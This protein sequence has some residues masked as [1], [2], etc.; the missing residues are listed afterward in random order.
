MVRVLASIHSVDIDRA[1]LND[2]GKH[3]EFS[4][5]ISFLF[6][7]KTAKSRTIQKDDYLLL[8]TCQF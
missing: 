3:G 2:F 7:L 6:P 1:G 5:S 4:L 8:A